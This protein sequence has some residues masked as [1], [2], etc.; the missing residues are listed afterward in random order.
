M[1]DTNEKLTARVVWKGVKEMLTKDGEE[2]KQEDLMAICLPFFELT[3]YENEYEFRTE[4]EKV[5]AEE[6][7]TADC[8]KTFDRDLQ[9]FCA[10][11]YAP[12]KMAYMQSFTGLTPW[13]LL[14][15][16]EAQDRWVAAYKRLIETEHGLTAIT[17]TRFDVCNWFA[18]WASPD[19][20]D[21]ATRRGKFFEEW[22]LWEKE[23]GGVYG[24][25]EVLSI[26]KVKEFA[27]DT[28]KYQES[29]GACL[30]LVMATD[31]W[32]ADNDGDEEALAQWPIV[33]EAYDSDFNYA[34]KA[35]QTM[36]G[37]GIGSRFFDAHMETFIPLIGECGRFQNISG[38]WAVSR[39]EEMFNTEL[40][41][42]EVAVKN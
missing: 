9:L 42:E 21:L 15:L 16:D 36:H 5:Q 18:K 41:A 1:T 39:L 33:Q 24:E 23:A 27:P 37:E 40:P 38:L 8:L 29:Y 31:A 14:Q 17:Q 4:L 26:E 19:A 35:L 22:D 12:V 7:F 2:L 20:G 34:V 3:D 10:V 30:A 13:G 6:A 25:G 11:G 28:L 32:Y